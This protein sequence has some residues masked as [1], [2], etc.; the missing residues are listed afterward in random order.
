MKVKFA[1]I[2]LI[3]LFLLITVMT[4][5]L[6]TH[7]NKT[8]GNYFFIDSSKVYQ[9]VV[10][11]GYRSPQ[12]L[13]KLADDYY[14]EAKYV[15][16]LRWYQEM[17]ESYP[18]EAYPEPISKEY[19]LRAAKSAKAL[20]QMDLAIDLIGQYSVMGGDPKVVLDFIK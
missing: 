3:G 4:G 2:S 10:E 11:R 17:F 8:D 5:D 18:N 6:Y 20:S 13:K 15:E 12:I 9:Q 1:H 16:A 19:Y 7:A 14:Y